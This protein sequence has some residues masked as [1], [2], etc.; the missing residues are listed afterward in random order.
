MKTKIMKTNSLSLRLLLTA[1]CM[2]VVL[3]NAVAA[4][5]VSSEEATHPTTDK[6]LTFLSS[7]PPLSEIQE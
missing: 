7:N 4:L 5:Y 2:P 3:A 1:L 6:L